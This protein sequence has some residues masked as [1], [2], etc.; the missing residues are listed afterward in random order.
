LKPLTVDEIEGIE[1]ASK[2]SCIRVGLV[3]TPSL[4]AEAT[5]W[6]ASE[7][8]ASL[9]QRFPDACWEVPYV[10]DGLVT[11]PAELTELVDA[12]RARLLD[13]DWDLVVCITDLPLRL[14]RRPL[15]THTSPT[16]GVALVSLPAFG[17][18]QVNRRLLDSIADAV[19]VLIGDTASDGTEQTE[20]ARTRT[21]QRLAELATDL[22]DPSESRRVVF[23]AR[24][25]TGNIRLLLGMIRANRPWR[26]VGHLSRA[27]LGGLAAGTFAL[28]QSDLW[29]IA[30]NLG[31]VRPI[32]LMCVAI[33]IAVVTMIVGHG[34]WERADNPR[35]REQVALF[36]LV[37]TVTV[38]VGIASLYGTVFV[39]SLGVGAL[40]IDSSLFTNAV[41]H[42]V[43]VSEYLHLAWLASSL[44]TFGGALGGVLETDEAVR[45]AAYAYR[46][47][48]R[49]AALG[50]EEPIEGAARDE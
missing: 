4:G 44:A 50:R 9:T 19:C 27:L 49:E 47:K 30:T 20:A 13:E 35:V 26:L 24:V 36:N 33:V 48:P 31:A 21:R 6:V 29:R 11:A 46:L 39:A 14:S 17:V 10:R 23:L 38:T 7:I 18:R 32:V 1:A 3:A 22:D 45:E 41:G 15:L 43:G 5:K 34:L 40:L 25:V 2:Q 8:A 42:R 12:A 16:H 28:V 37:T